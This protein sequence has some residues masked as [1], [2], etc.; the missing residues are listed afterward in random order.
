MPCYH[1]PGAR[2]KCLKIYYY[3]YYYYKKQRPD[4]KK[5]QANEVDLN[6]LGTHELHMMMQKIKTSCDKED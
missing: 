5:V 1:W 2:R 3:Y 6:V 4:E